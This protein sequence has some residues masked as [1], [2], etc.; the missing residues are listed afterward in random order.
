MMAAWGRI[1]LWAVQIV[2]AL[3]FLAAGFAKLTAA[4]AMVQMF[5][6]IGVGQWLRYLTGTIEVTSSILLLFPFT[7]TLAALVLVG[8]M[9]GAVLAHLTILD[10]SPVA[11]IVLMIL[12]GAIG[13]GRRGASAV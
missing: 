8:T 11:P 4:P 3:A 10:S 7:A 13:W 9:L 2:T 5:A 12:C 6:T 1:A